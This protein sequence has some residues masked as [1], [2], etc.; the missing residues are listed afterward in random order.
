[1][2]AMRSYRVIVSKKAVS[3]LDS[4]AAYVASLYRP[5]SGHKY[6]NRI[7]GQIAELAFTADICP[8]SGFAIAK[9][10]HPH[11]KTLSVANHRW[12]VVFHIFESFVVVDRIIP[13]KMMVR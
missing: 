11:A 6:V 5:E 12:T 2:I 1:M 7:L 8:P 9:E 3:D 13:S 4:I 10:V